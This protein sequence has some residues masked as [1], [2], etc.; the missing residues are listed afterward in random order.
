MALELPFIWLESHRDVEWSNFFSVAITDDVTAGRPLI[1]RSLLRT[2]YL[3]LC[4]TLNAQKRHF[5]LAFL[6][7][8]DKC[9]VNGAVWRTLALMAIE[10]I[11]LFLITCFVNRAYIRFDVFI[12]DCTQFHSHLEKLRYYSIFSRIA[13]INIFLYMCLLLWAIVKLNKIFIHI[14]K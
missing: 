11:S 4:W 10:I 8:E 12:T 7:I 6:N 5:C 2:R 9:S 3:L 13:I 1:K 14:L